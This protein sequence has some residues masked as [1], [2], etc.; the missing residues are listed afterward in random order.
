MEA[1]PNHACPLCGRP[2]GCA[3]AA[4]GS[5]PGTCWCTEVA[6]DA[7]VLALV[8]QAQRGQSCLCA[9][10]ARRTLSADDMP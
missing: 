2:N 10:C 8:P 7:G 6:I 4:R 1:K 9:T 5:L 3:P